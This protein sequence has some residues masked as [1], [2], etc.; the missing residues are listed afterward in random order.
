MQVPN[1]ERFALGQGL[2]QIEPAFDYL[3]TF[4]D[5]VERNV[6]FVV[7]CGIGTDRGIYLREPADF[8]RPKEVGV[9]IEP[10]FFEGCSEFAVSPLIAGILTII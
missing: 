7:S 10:K 5:C 4:S 1:I 9:W 6:R 2:L 8:E 3:R